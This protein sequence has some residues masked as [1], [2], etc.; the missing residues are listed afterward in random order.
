MRYTECPASKSVVVLIAI[1]CKQEQRDTGK[2]LEQQ[3]EQ[4][5]QY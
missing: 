3:N 2:E 1:G 4:K 5:K